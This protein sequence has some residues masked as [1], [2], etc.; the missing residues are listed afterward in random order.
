MSIEDGLRELFR[1]A[2]EAEVFAEYV[3]CP[4]GERRDGEVRVFAQSVKGL[5]ERAVSP[6][7]DAAVVAW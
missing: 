2:G 1:G 7:A 6:D 3:R 4:R 5:G